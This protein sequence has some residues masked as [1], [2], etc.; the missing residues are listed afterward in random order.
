[1]WVKTLSASLNAHPN[2]NILTV[3]EARFSAIM[4]R[5]TSPASVLGLVDTHVYGTSKNPICLDG[6][7]DDD[8]N[9]TPGSPTTPG[10][11]SPPAVSGGHSP[12]S[13][14]PSALVSVVPSINLP[15]TGALGL[16]SLY[17][18][19]EDAVLDEVLGWN[20]DAKDLSVIKSTEEDNDREEAWFM[21]AF[22]NPY[23]WDGSHIC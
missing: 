9:T 15:P 22:F 23:I 12:S 19:E 6:D 10:V 8:I 4:S 16:P 14:T 17:I 5:V 21:G 1:M 13:A 11:S 7:D 2:G 20:V 3:V 18:E